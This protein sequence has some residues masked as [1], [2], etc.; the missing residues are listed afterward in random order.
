MQGVLIL[1]LVL[2]Q[3]GPHPG[4]RAAAAENAQKTKGSSGRSGM[5]GVVLPMYAVGIVVYLVYTLLKVNIK[6]LLG[7]KGNYFKEIM[8]KRSLI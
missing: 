4:M 7:N 5:M 2:F 8:V 6:L 1:S 3:P